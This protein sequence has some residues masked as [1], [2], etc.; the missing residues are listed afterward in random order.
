VLVD[1]EKEFFIAFSVKGKYANMGELQKELN[2]VPKLT[3]ELNE[4]QKKYD[5]LNKS[6]KE[7]KEE[8]ES[9]TNM[10]YVFLGLFVIFLVLSPVMYVVGKK[11]GVSKAVKEEGPSEE[12]SEEEGEE[13]EEE[14]SNE[15]SEE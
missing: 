6:Y 5:D 11:Q 13:I 3:N 9:A 2:K 8:K 12:L 10:E 15:E 1:G 4:L 14:S 7:L